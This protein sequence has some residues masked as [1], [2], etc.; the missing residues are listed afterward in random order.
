MMILELP[1][2]DLS[3]YEN[4]QTMRKVIPT[5]ESLYEVEN[6]SKKH[7]RDI[8]FTTIFISYGILEI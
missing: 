7:G 5:R 3:K 4:I 8:P 1:Y 6:I 2:P